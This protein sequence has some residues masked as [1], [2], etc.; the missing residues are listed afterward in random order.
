MVKHGGG[1]GGGLVLLCARLWPPALQFWAVKG[2]D[3]GPQR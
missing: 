1:G 2:E 3:K